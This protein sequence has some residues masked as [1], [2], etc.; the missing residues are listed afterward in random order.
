MPPHQI[1]E[2]DA[3]LRRVAA[4]ALLWFPGLGRLARVPL[5]GKV[6][7]RFGERVIPRSYRVVA[8]VR[9]GPGAGLRLA[10]NP[11]TGRTLWSGSAEAEVQRA[12]TRFLYQGAVFF[13]VGANLGFYSL[14]AA[15]LVGTNGRVYSFEPDPD[16][17][18]LLLRN[19]E[20]NGFSNVRAFQRA[21]WRS[22]GTVHFKRADPGMSPDRGTGR[23][24]SGF[25]QGGDWLR[26]T[27][28]TLDELAEQLEPPDVIKCD[29]EG[30]E[31]DVV[32]GGR[33]I[34]GARKPVVIVEIHSSELGPR[35]AR[36]LGELGY[37]NSWL[38]ATHM[39]GVP[40]APK[41]V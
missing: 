5:I 12:L 14:L 25:F 15:R 24:A 1:L 19:V 28:V 23:V 7:G 36:L 34:L 29:A 37:Q 20:L 39:L 21:V 13:D 38:T 16:V 9:G 30:A 3:G 40:R 2:G 35:I 18:L 4:L 26:V 8:S 11:R 17:F 41:P 6:L 32:L 22:A 10:L 33:K 27:A 31:E